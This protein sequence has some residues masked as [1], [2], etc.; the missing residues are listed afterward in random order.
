MLPQ[1]ARQA[2]RPGTVRVSP[3]ARPFRSRCPWT[4]CVSVH[5]FPASGVA[6]RI[7]SPHHW[8]LRSRQSPARPWV[9]ILSAHREHEGRRHGRPAS[10]RCRAVSFR[11]SDRRPDVPLTDAQWARIGP[12]LPDRTP[13]WGSRW[14]DHREV[15]DAIAFGFPTGAQPERNGCTCRRHAATGEAF[16]PAVRVGRRRHLGTGVHHAHGN[17]PMLRVT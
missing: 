6:V 13:K 8:R 14:R 16:R 1:D 15:I 10:S 9:L 4:S 7:S 5:C 12:L 17:R 3:S 2:G 11:S